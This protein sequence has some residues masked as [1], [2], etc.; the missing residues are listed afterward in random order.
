MNSLIGIGLRYPHYQTM[1][2]ERPS[3]GWL[4]VHS[5]NFFQAGGPVIDQLLAIREHYPL[6]LHGVG[7]SLGS[8]TGILKNHLERLKHLIETVEPFL[9]SEHL[10]WSRVNGIYL[11]DLLPLPYTPESL[12]IFCRNLSVAQDFLGREIL[13]ENPST[14][15]EYRASQIEEVDFLI[16]LCQRTGAKILLDLNNVFVSCSNHGWNALQ[17]IDAIPTELIKEIHLAGHS[18][19]TIAPDQ[20]LRVDTHDNWVAEEV[21]DLFDYTLQ[22]A[23]P[24]P[25]LLEWDAQ[26]PALSVLINEAQK[27]LHYFPIREAL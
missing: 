22:K 1:L 19:K 17:Y 15:I 3:I 7:L 10:S 23:G 21:W 5:E 2:Q 4:E 27:A 18:L 26:I 6:S 14:Y 20:T 11:P 9:I 24:K 12:D 25:T 16:T 13:I 8:A